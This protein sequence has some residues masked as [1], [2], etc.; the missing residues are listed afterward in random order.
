MRLGA[1]RAWPL[2]KIYA[3]EAYLP[4]TEFLQIGT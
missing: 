4:G 1:A 3:A 2:E